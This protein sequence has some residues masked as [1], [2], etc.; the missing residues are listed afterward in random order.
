M[1]AAPSLLYFPLKWFL[2]SRGIED[3]SPKDDF[4]SD[5]SLISLHTINR[6]NSIATINPLVLSIVNRHR[7]TEFHA[8]KFRNSEIE[9]TQKVA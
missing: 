8:S 5:P 3:A 9:F 1:A 4:S 6:S 7:S 2:S